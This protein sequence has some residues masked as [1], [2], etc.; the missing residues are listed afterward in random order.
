[1]KSKLKFTDEE[2]E[3]ELGE[4]F[5][6]PIDYDTSADEPVPAPDGDVENTPGDSV[7]SVNGDPVDYNIT[8][9][10]TADATNSDKPDTKLTEPDNK[11][12]FTKEDKK[13]EKLEKKNDKYSKKRDAARK[14]MPTQRKKVTERIYNETKGKAETKIRFKD[15]IIP[16]NEAKWNKP[17]K[18]SLPEQGINKV[19]AKAFG[20]IHAK[21]SE[22]EHEN[23]GTQ[24]AHRAELTGEKIYDKGKQAAKSIYRFAKNTPYR[25]DAKYETK[26]IKT[27]M[28]IDYQKA[29]KDNPELKSNPISRSMQKRAIKKKYAESLRKAKKTGET[30]KKTGSVV[31]KVVQ[32]VKKLVSKNPVVMLMA[33]LLLIVIFAVMSM[34]T[35]CV[36]MFSGGAGALGAASYAAADEDI[37]QVELSYTEWE[38][39]LRLEIQ[40]TE[41]THSGYDEYIYNIGAIRHDPHEVMAFLTAVYGD[42]A[43]DD[44][45]SVLR[46]IFDQQYTLEYVTDMEIRTRTETNTDY[47]TDDDGNYILDDDGN[48]IEYE[49][50]EEVEYEWYILTV[51]LKSVPLT[52]ILDPLMTDEQREHFAILMQTKGARQYGASPFNF[53][54]QPYVTSYYGY[55]IHPITGVKDLHRGIDIGVPE[56]TEILAGVDGTVTVATFD[57]SYGNYIVI[58]STDGIEMKYAHCHTLLVSAGQSVAKSDVI[59]TVG[60]TGDA[61]G[62]H[63]HMEILRNG[64]YLNPIFFVAPILY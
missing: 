40:D 27:R 47:L 19:K 22:T 49:Y 14:K 60:N 53:A 57:G 59:A 3:K 1:M 58:E 34:F 18:Q 50:E 36:N 63:L 29:V 10:G 30:V 17:K 26:S 61:T 46:D 11:L 62:A 8:P 52:D 38:T 32:T 15:E 4:I 2:L 25:Q 54:W 41:T 43:Y 64:I 24:T 44:I 7:D 28:E 5:E 35:M 42:F 9:D 6:L 20:K 45:E 56:G 55:R 21:V 37:E 12:K 13:I 48:L 16:M 33:G 31:A 51:N 39:D 23:V